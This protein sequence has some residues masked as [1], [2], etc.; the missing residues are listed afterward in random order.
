MKNDYM[1]D[2]RHWTHRDHRQRMDRKQWRTILL[3]SADTIVFKA[4]VVKLVADDIG[5]GVVEVYKDMKD[6]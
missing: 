3:A 4:N 6:K 5:Y 2:S 1:L